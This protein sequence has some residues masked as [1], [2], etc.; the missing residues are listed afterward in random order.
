M[1]LPTDT[2]TVKFAVAGPA[3]SAFDYEIQA[4]KLDEHGIAL[5]ERPRGARSSR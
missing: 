4:P 5:L 2:E 1:R 3:E